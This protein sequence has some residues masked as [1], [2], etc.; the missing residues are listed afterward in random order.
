MIVTLSKGT[1][2]CYSQE[3]GERERVHGYGSTLS[4]AVQDAYAK[5]GAVP[6]GAKIARL[7]EDMEAVV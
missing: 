5:L 4:A 7:T 6:K 2:I 1:W 3:P